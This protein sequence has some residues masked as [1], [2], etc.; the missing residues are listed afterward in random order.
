MSAFT[1]TEFGASQFASSDHFA[2]KVPTQVVVAS[3]VAPSKSITYRFPQQIIPLDDGRTLLRLREAPLLTVDSNQMHF[4]VEN[5]GIKM[6]CEDVADLP[7]QI[8]RRFLTLFS[9]ADNNVIGE[10][11]RL[12]WLRIL[13]FVDCTQF[14]IERSAPQYAE[15]TLLKKNPLTVEWHDGSNEVLSPS[16]ASIFFPLNPGDNFSAFIKTGKEQRT[17]VVERISLIPV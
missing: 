14:N 8:A 10:E 2:N 3:S 17:L 11:E 16:L 4:E 7:R 15:G 5:W 12:E 13:D 1:A 9:K 6:N